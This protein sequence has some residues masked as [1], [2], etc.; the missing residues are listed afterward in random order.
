MSTATSMNRH[1]R[2]LST[3]PSS[4]PNAIVHAEGYERVYELAD[5]RRGA[6]L[7]D[8]RINVSNAHT[9][10]K[11]TPKFCVEM[12]R[13]DRLNWSFGVTLADLKHF[14]KSVRQSV[15]KRCK[16]QQKMLLHI[17]SAS[18]RTASVSSLQSSCSSAGKEKPCDTCEQVAQELKQWTRVPTLGAIGK[19]HLDEKCDLVEQFLQDVFRLLYS[20]AQS[21]HNCELLREVLRKTEQLCCIK[22]SNDRGAI[23]VIKTLKRVP[24]PACEDCS[25]CLNRLH[26]QRP[27]QKLLKGAAATTDE[28]SKPVELA[29][30]HR[31]HDTC[32]CMWFH[33]RLNCPICRSQ[34][35]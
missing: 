35:A 2:R 20:H 12:R 32:I 34:S 25:I 29:C 10:S 5:I 9:N 7:R 31:F 21:M 17:S 4:Q 27:Q 3:S 11:F 15:K 22:Y 30:G 8:V 23:C 19:S 16:K 18:H 33:T 1:T 24:Q 14:E 13:P 6:S 28:P 26:T